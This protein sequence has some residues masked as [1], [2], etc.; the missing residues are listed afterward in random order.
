MENKK[1]SEVDRLINVS[2]IKSEMQQYHNYIKQ[3]DNLESWYYNNLDYYD[4]KIKNYEEQ[5][6]NIKSPNSSGDIAVAK[7]IDKSSQINSIMGK[8]KDAKNSKTLWLK[9]NNSIYFTNLAHWNQR[10]ATVLSYVDSIENKKE[11]EFIRKMY[12]D[13]VDYR[14]LMKEYKIENTGSLYRK[15][16]NILKKLV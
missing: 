10:I 11:K 8:I 14:E 16:T 4:Q 6:N 13:K 3:H 9:E 2:L 15:A 1:I 7:A 12:I 5:M